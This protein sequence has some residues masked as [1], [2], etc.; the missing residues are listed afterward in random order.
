MDQIRQA[1]KDRVV[2]RLAGTGSN[3]PRLEIDEMIIDQPDTFN[4]FCLAMG[5]LKSGLAKDWMGYYQIAGI[6]GLPLQAWDNVAAIV[7]AIDKKKKKA[8]DDDEG[9]CPHSDP[10]FPTWHRP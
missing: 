6:H 1:Q 2:I 4:L 5:E 10:K 7:A 8:L 9:Y 3:L